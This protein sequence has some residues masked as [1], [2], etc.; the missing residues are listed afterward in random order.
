[1]CTQVPASQMLALPTLALKMLT[2]Q[3]LALRILDLQT[4]A[5][6]MFR[7]W[8]SSAGASCVISLASTTLC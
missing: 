6:Q 5:V 7:S 2:L 8:P 1:M 4:L 3:T